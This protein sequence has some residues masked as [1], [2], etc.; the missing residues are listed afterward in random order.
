MRSGDRTHLHHTVLSAPNDGVER[1]FHLPVL[2][3]EE[4]EVPLAEAAE[5]MKNIG[6]RGQVSPDLEDYI[7]TLT[8]INIIIS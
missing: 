8:N 7:H 6:A 5:L 2:F 3:Q 4:R 1:E